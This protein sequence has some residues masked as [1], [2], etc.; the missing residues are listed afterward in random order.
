MLNSERTSNRQ[1][2]SLSRLC[3][4]LI[5]AVHIGWTLPAVAITEVRFAHDNVQYTCSAL[6]A[7]SPSYYSAEGHVIAVIVLGG[8][9]GNVHVE[10]VQPDGGV[11]LDNTLPIPNQSCWAHFFQI[12]QT[13]PPRAIG[14]WTLRLTVN[15]GQP[16]TAQF[17]ILAGAPPQPPPLPINFAVTP[18]GDDMKITWAGVS[19][20]TGYEIQR[21]SPTS[22]Y[23]QVALAI[24]NTNPEY[25]DHVP[26]SNTTYCYRMR[27]FN[28]NSYSDYTN[29][30]CAIYLVPPTLLRPTDGASLSPGSVTLEWSSVAGATGY[31]LRVGGSCGSG[32]S[33]D[34]TTSSPS[35]TTSFSSGTYIWQTQ[36]VS[37]SPGGT[38]SVSECHT[39]TIG[40]P[41]PSPPTAQFTSSPSNPLTGD[42]VSFADTSTGNPTS[43]IWNFGDGQ[44]S[45]AQSPTHVFANAGRFHVT[46]TA[47]STGGP[48]T[49]AGADITVS[50]KVT[51]PVADFSFSPDSP[52]AATPVQ[53]TD[54]STGSPTTET[55]DF[56]DG[57]GGVGATVTHT[58]QVAKPYSVRLTVS[59]SAGPDSK[60]RDV[61]VSPTPVPPCPGCITVTGQVTV[62]G[63]ALVRGRADRTVTA[64]NG[65]DAKTTAIS[66]RGTYSL[67]L[68]PGTWKLTASITYSG[69]FL[70]GSP[71][72]ARVAVATAEI[73]VPAVTTRNI[74]FG[75]PVVFIHGIQAD[76]SRWDSWIDTL[77]ALDRSVVALAPDYIDTD[78]YPVAG[79]DVALQ[80][81][82]ALNDLAVG[83]PDLRVIAHSKGG[84]IIR[85]II[86][87]QPSYDR[88]VVDVIELGTPNRGTDCYAAGNLGGLVT[89]QFRLSASDVDSSFAGSDD[90][91]ILNRSIHAIAGTANSVP[92]FGLNVLTNVCQDSCE[93]NDGFV[94]VSSVFNMRSGV[95][96]GAIPGFVV[97][98]PHAALGGLETKW[99]LT[100]VIAPYYGVGG[101]AH[102]GA[103]PTCTI[104]VD[105]A[106]AD[107]RCMNGRGLTPQLRCSIPSAG[108]AYAVHIKWRD[109]NG[110]DV[111]ALPQD[112]SASMSLS[113]LTC[114]AVHAVWNVLV[115]ISGYRI[116]R[117]TS[118]AFTKS[119]GELLG[120]V[121]YGESYDFVDTPPLVGGPYYYRVSTVVGSG[122][123]GQL[124]APAYL[125]ILRRRAGG[126]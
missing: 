119:E 31:K 47:S 3:L 38:S 28:D 88:H 62:G 116:Y 48:S 111:Y 43:W 122:G 5:V 115:N 27:S 70:S 86:A 71:R 23:Q 110:N 100:D 44:T 56:G 114:L 15:G 64:S 102:L 68:T 20:A 55:W 10:W 98:Y 9:S 92:N 99:I 95:A 17:T 67:D 82:A 26:L 61:V 117:G 94:P 34:T 42:P 97:P 59:N 125:P 77:T 1:C 91:K 8:S 49:P 57:N 4:R 7:N 106:C 33:I 104:S 6:P 58:F 32:S 51:K 25:H 63:N 45:A 13:T 2:P 83:D 16:F 36:A 46:L 96:S 81:N 52:T 53:F 93:P 12:A 123:E 105:G 101:S 29:E 65:I 120:F 126:I 108:A 39:L 14:T 41:P 113:P 118:E 109:P 85:W 80:L 69:L 40:T 60:T 75:D 76:P 35:F 103:F 30:V 84:L 21:K 89:A 37:S 124:S 50:A 79:G 19:S 90:A 24:G 22:N 121:A 11:A 18:Y 74:S 54:Q 78:D 107:E 66:E 72:P 112:V 73:A 87:T